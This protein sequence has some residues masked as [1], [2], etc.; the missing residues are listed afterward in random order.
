MVSITFKL[1]ETSGI[2]RLTPLNKVW[3]PFIIAATVTAGSVQD[4]LLQDLYFERKIAGS[5]EPRAISNGNGTKGFLIR[6]VIIRVTIKM[7]RPHN[8]PH[9]FSLFSF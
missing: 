1:P 5:S 7:G 9:W 6:S 4:G 3:S 2:S 8:F